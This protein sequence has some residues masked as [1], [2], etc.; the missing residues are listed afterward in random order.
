MTRGNTRARNAIV[1]APRSPLIRIVVKL[2]LFFFSFFY[3]S[4][5][6]TSM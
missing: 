6:E 2:L 1:T 5:D 3:Y 4:S